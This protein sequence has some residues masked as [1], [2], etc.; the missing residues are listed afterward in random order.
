MLIHKFIKLFGQ[1]FYV[2]LDNIKEVNDWVDD[3]MYLH[4]IC[5][6]EQRIQHLKDARKLP[7][8]T[9]QEHAMVSFFFPEF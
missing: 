1:V 3:K 6:D 2:K 5:S 4:W 8:E 7:P 9:K